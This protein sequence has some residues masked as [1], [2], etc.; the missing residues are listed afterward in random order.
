MP[1][2]EI[3]VAGVCERDVDLLLLEEFIASK[4]FRKWF[5]AVV[6][7]QAQS[8]RLVQ[9][10]RSVTFSN[11][12]SDLELTF[13]SDDGNRSLPGER[14]VRVLDQIK[15]WQRIPGVI[16]CDYGPELLR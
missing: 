12:E 14:V 8:V 16:R 5:L 15:S 13:E 11:G 7:V 9:A 4:S 2:P 1:S 3:S 6:G 10:A